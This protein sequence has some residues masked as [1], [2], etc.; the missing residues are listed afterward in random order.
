[1]FKSL[2]VKANSPQ[3]N[4]MD[5]SDLIA[6]MHNELLYH[7]YRINVKLVYL[8]GED[9]QVKGVESFCK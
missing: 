7:F 1:M 3:E 2:R 8:Q 4:K 9:S 6:E 5:E